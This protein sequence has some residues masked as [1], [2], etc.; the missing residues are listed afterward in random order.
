M[1][2][3]DLIDRREARRLGDALAR[4]AT[5]VTDDMGERSGRLA[6]DAGGI[7]NSILQRALDYGRRELPVLAEHARDAVDSGRREFPVLAR[8]ARQALEAGR[9]EWPEVA[10]QARGAIDYGRAQ[11]PAIAEQAS[12]VARRAGASAR[13]ATRAARSRSFPVLV[14]AVGLLLFASLVSNSSAAAPVATRRAPALKAKAR[15]TATRS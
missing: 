15:R 10:R 6:H 4:R 2:W 3:L 14:G 1:A 9:R 11:L 13:R 12:L 7:A 5:S 8:Q